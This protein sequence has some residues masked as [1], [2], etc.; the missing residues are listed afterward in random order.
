MNVI[1]YLKSPYPIERNKWKIIISVSLFV[2]FFILFFQ[3]FGLQRMA[4]SQKTLILAGYGAVTFIM[5]V[6][7]LMLI[8]NLFK[9]VFSDKRWNIAKQIAWLLWILFS[10]GLGNY[11]Y[12]ILTIPVIRHSFKSFLVFQGFTLAIGIFPITLITIIVHAVLQK[13]N[14]QSALK[15]NENIHPA[16]NKLKSSGEQTVELTNENGRGGLKVLLDSLLFIESTG[17]YITV[18]WT[19]NEKPE[20]KMLRNTLKEAMKQL[21]DFPAVFQCHR[22]YLVNLKRI[23]DV[24]GNAQ[25]Y[26][27]RVSGNN[28][29][30]PVSRN[31]IPAFNR[32]MAASR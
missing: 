17:N 15:L 26:Q 1:D 23:E 3:P 7:D 21:S 19:E 20:K 29:L 5:L 24:K 2:S 8:E 10:I 30:V 28:S 9:Q 12:S 14:L 16:E 11:L 13:K 32:E 6:F 31:Y 27:L 18:H 4:S 25:G 22:A